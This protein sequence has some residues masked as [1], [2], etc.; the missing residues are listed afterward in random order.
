MIELFRIGFLQITLIDVLDIGIVTIL[1][2]SLYT[3]LRDT[4]AVRILLGFI[5]MLIVSFI[6]QSL[7]LKALN[8]ILRAIADIWL[9]A[10]IILFQPEIRR[11]LLLVTR[12]KLF[13]VIVKRNLSQTL[14]HIVEAVKELS[15]RHVGALLVFPRSQNIKMTIDTGIPIQALVS[16]ELLLSLFN[17]K[18]PLHD[19]AVIIENDMITAAKCVLPLSTMSRN[20]LGNLGTRHRAALGLSEQSD[21]VIVIVSEETGAISLAREGHLTQQVGIKTFP[22]LLQKYL[23]SGTI[24]DAE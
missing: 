13:R 19:G 6:T 12:T 17:P 3:V 20:D 10:F 4:I 18:S 7:N 16:S 9:I 15:D 21:A 1:F 14:D 23:S 22:T 5:L 11:V 8:W 24:S 2:F